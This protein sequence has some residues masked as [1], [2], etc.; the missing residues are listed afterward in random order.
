MY[1]EQEK[2]ETSFHV[3]YTKKMPPKINV[4]L[5]REISLVNNQIEL[6]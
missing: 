4:D 1:F 6:S 5:A 3:S 2:F